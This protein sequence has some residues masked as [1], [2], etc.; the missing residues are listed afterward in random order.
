MDY[1][2]VYSLL[3]NDLKRIEQQLEEALQANSPLLKET[4]L[5]Y[6]HA[7]GKRIR[8]VLVLLSSKFGNENNSLIR[9]VAVSLELIHMASL[10]HDD[11]VDNADLRRGRPTVKAKWDNRIAMYTGDYILARS[12]ELITKLE[13]EEAHR[14]LSHTMVELSLGEIEQIR[15]KFNF[16]QPLTNY[17]RRIKRKTALLIAS[18]CQLGAIAAGAPSWIHRKL[19]RFGYYVGMAFQIT[20]D[21]LDF[22]STEEKLGKPVGSDLLQGNITLPVLFA[23]KKPELK[24]EITKVP[25]M[26]DGDIKEIV[27]L[28]K[29]TGAI[30]QSMTIS[31]K[32]VQKAIDVL[33][34]LP[35]HETKYML[36]QMIQFVVHRKS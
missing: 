8:P 28:I 24:K 25:L 18:C 12:L 17:F 1:R 2:S 19:F 22:T 36:K 30:E 5:H 4:S 34:D 3:S 9:D 31:K 26:E 14:V 29:G 23:L 35:D 21:I 27:E 33:E 11:V 10:I 7:G 32:Y 13:H 15:D 16:D 20:D 6:L